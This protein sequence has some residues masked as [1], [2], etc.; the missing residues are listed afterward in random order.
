RTALERREVFSDSPT[1]PFVKKIRV[2][3]HRH[4]AGTTD[5][6][7]VTASHCR[8][9]GSLR[10]RLEI[11]VQVRGRFWAA[12]ALLDDMGQLMC[13]QSL[14][15]VRSGSV[16]STSEDD[17]LANGVSL[18]VDFFRGCCGIASYVEPYSAEVVAETALHVG[19]NL[20]RQR[21]ARRMQRLLDRTVAQSVL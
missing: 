5:L 19:T 20:R 14:T 13:Q 11:A 16:V 18:G 10:T 6:H 12:P 4:R 3:R 2:P 17:V 21:L 9:R 7:R 15:F 1:P 8:A